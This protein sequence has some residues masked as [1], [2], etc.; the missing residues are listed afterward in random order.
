MAAV[1]AK[2]TIQDICLQA[3]ASRT[4]VSRV[5]NKRP[6]VNKVKRER[7]L[8]VIEKLKYTP[9]ATARNLRQSRTETIGVIFPRFEGAVFSDFLSGIE[10]V[11]QSQRYHILTATTAGAHLPIEASLE[12]TLRLIDERR[13][14]GLILFDPARQSKHERQLRKYSIP[15][16]LALRRASPSNVSSVTVDHF[17]GGYDA[18][19]HLIDHGYKRIATLTGLPITEDARDRLRGYETALKDHFL[20]LDPSLVVEGTFVREPSVRA[21]LRHFQNVPWPQ[22]VFAANDDM[23]LG[24]LQYTRNH[25]DPAVRATAIVGFDDVDLA[26]YAGLTTI[27]AD[28]RQVGRRC[29]ELLLESIRHK[30]AKSIPTRHEVIPVNL[31]VRSSCGCLSAPD[32]PR[33]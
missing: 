30:D 29:A 21:F 27:H 28:I 20:P 1:M 10:E 4:A 11:T 31:V 25:E 3:K 12:A 2:V 32:K 33:V 19:K 17:Q 5:L 16:V 7:I 18:T 24:L 26:H 22:A 23:A 13:V 15:F 6:G 8:K 14:D 9:S